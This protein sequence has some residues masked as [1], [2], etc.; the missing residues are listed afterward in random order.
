VFRIT[1]LASDGP[2]I[3][4]APYA[5]LVKDRLAMPVITIASLLLKAF[6]DSALKKGK[7]IP[8]DMVA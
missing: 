3:G 1:F 2:Y 7:K 6:V 4:E 8:N 5:V